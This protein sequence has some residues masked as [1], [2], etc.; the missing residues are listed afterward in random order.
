MLQKLDSVKLLLKY[1]ATF[2]PVLPVGHECKVPIETD[3]EE[4]RSWK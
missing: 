3:S 2:L 1:F 4:S